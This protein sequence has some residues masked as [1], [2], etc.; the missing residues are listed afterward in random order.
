MRILLAEEEPRIA[1]FVSRGLREN[2]YAVD[3]VNNGEDAVYRTIRNQTHRIER[4]RQCFFSDFL[5]LILCLIFHLLALK[6]NEF[7]YYNF[8]DDQ[9]IFRAKAKTSVRFF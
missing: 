6:T 5:S 9:C 4:L 8:C 3:V 7:F 2:S 1:N